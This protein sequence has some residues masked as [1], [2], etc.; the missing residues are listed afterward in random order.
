MT[1]RQVGDRAGCSAS[2]ITLLEQGSRRPSLD[3]LYHVT[4]A[5]D[6]DF[7]HAL[8]LMVFDAGIPEDRTLRDFFRERIEE[9]KLAQDLRQAGVAKIA[10]RASG[11][12][13]A[14]RRTVLDMI[15]YIR[16]AQGLNDEVES[17]GSPGEE[18]RCERQ[19][20]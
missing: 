20:E 17:E 3:L 15:E 7:I 9:L 2:F 16:K 1:T 6:G 12:D 4:Q 13:E 18:E 10:T 5:L 19:E 14:G 11:L 8:S